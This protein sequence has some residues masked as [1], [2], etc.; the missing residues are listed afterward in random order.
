MPRPAPLR[1][2]FTTVFD[3]ISG[4]ALRALV[5]R[6]VRWFRGQRADPAARSLGE[7]APLRPGRVRVG[8]RGNVGADGV[9]ES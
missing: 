9:G 2:R 3:D 6:G 8:V 4:Y 5:E 7:D 1:T